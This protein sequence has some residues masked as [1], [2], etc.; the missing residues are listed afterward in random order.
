MHRRKTHPSVLY[1]YIIPSSYYWLSSIPFYLILYIL[2]FSFIW[3][4][5][6]SFCI[7]IFFSF[8]F[9]NIYFVFHFGFKFVFLVPCC[10]CYCC[11][12]HSFIHSLLCISF[13]FCAS[14][15]LFYFSSI[16]IT[17][18]EEV[19]EKGRCYTK[20]IIIWKERN[21]LENAMFYWNLTYY[22]LFCRRIIVK[23][24]YLLSFLLNYHF[25]FNYLYPFP[26][27][28]P[29]NSLMAANNTTNQQQ[30]CK[31]Q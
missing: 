9:Y 21:N 19:E 30:Q 22:L 23:W 8:S 26:F 31:Q 15:S 24:C 10:C 1:V 11:L 29:L 27:I 28:K 17:W 6:L 14:Q 2:A 25:F 7:Y 12:I 5:L 18:Q 13:F 16:L 4:I 20:K 3:D